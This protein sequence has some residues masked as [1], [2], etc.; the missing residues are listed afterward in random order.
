[1]IGLADEYGLDT[2][3]FSACLMEPAMAQ[4]VMRQTRESL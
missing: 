4:V 3:R 1:M 2:T